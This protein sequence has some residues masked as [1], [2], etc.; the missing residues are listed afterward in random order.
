MARSGHSLLKGPLDKFINPTPL[1]NIFDALVEGL[2][3]DDPGISSPSV[4]KSSAESMEEVV[5]LLSS[6]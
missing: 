4:Q 5:I 1:H 6:Q 2:V 3:E